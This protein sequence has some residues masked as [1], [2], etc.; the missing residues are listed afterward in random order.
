MYTQ[1]LFVSIEYSFK[2]C[3]FITF[4]RSYTRTP[5]GGT[6]GTA[7]PPWVKFWI[8][9]FPMFM[10]YWQNLSSQNQTATTSYSFL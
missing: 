7:I 1:L 2:S 6:Q 9:R 8:K 4:L 3:R 10:K 5:S